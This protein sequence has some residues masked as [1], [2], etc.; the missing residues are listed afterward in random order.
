MNAKRALPALSLVLSLASTAPTEAAAPAEAAS[1]IKAATPA[2][3]LVGR[4]LVVATPGGDASVDLGCAPLAALAAGDRVHV[5]CGADGAVEV[6]LGPAPAVVAHR[7]YDAAVTGH[8][9]LDGAVWVRLARVEARP[10]EASTSAPVGAPPVTPSSLPEPAATPA[11]SRLAVLERHPGRVIVASPPDAPLE[12]GAHV[13]LFVEHPVDLGGGAG[14]TREERVAIGRVSAAGDGRAEVE[15]GLGERVPP[16]ALARPT[17]APLTASMFTSPRL[18]GLWDLRFALRP[19]LALGTVGFGMVDELRA[20][21]RFEAPV[22]VHA[23]VEPLGLGIADAGNI[24]ALAGNVVVT[25]DSALFEVGLGLGWSAVNGDLLT[26]SYD[27]GSG[28]GSYE[29]KRVKHGLSLA[30]LARL[31]A[32]DGL[33]L[34]IFNSFILHDDEFKYGGTRVSVQVPVDERLWF[35][36]TGGGGLAGYAFGEIGLRVL[37]TGNGDRGTVFLTPTLGAAGL[38]GETEVSCTVWNPTLGQEEAGTCTQ[39]IDYSG[40]MVG[41]IMEYR[42]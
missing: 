35:V 14:A 3:A 11:P 27:S 41:I 9:V 36:M 24:L 15:L 29:F 2:F 4:S 38:F 23:M 25:Y 26:S 20:T 37:V 21:W 32:T 30:Q 34:S 40:P 8:F 17:S 5:A 1:A 31:G 6:A 28:T 33:N 12:R 10:L 18:P 42:P 39:D 22:A 7:S 19:F 13:E 16:S